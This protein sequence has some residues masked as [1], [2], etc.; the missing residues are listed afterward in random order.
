MVNR[1]KRQLK[2]SESILPYLLVFII[3]PVAFYFGLFQMGGWLGII[4]GIILVFFLLN[5]KS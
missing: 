3:L 4:I 1:K 2:K 5:K